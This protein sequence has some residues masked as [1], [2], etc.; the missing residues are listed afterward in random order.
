[1]PTN[2]TARTENIV[3]HRTRS[4]SS[5]AHLDPVSDSRSTTP[6]SFVFLCCAMLSLL[7]WRWMFNH[8]ARKPGK[9]DRSGSWVIEG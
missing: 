3:I 8:N 9:K 6:Y 4:R 5:I 1:M 7:T 2:A